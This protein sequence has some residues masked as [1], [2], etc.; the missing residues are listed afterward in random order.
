MTDE[1]LKKLSAIDLRVLSKSKKEISQIYSENSDL[2]VAVK[3]ER[4]YSFRN[5]DSRFWFKVDEIRKQPNGILGC[6]I[7]SRP[8]LI[9]IPVYAN[10]FEF[11]KKISGMELLFLRV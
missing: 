6:K 5:F 4:L 8:I 2:I 7:T 11:I 10:V 3:T 1:E 9:G